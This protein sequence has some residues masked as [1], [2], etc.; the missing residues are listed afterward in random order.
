[1]LLHEYTHK[2]LAIWHLDALRDG[3]GVEFAVA[4]SPN[5]IRTAISLCNCCFCCNCT[6]QQYKFE[7]EY[8]ILSL[9]DSSKSSSFFGL[10]KPLILLAYLQF[11]TGLHSLCGF[12]QLCLG[13]VPRKEKVYSNLFFGLSIDL[14]QNE[15]E[16][17]SWQL[18]QHLFDIVLNI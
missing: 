12:M 4:F 13:V 1:M 18:M 2:P 8:D 10:N 5:W 14:C 7:K 6:C 17:L 11:L 9:W 15:Y 3:G 16:L